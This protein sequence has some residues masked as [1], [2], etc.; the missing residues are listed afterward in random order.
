MRSRYRTHRTRAIGGMSPGP[1]AASSPAPLYTTPFTDASATARMRR[2]SAPSDGAAA[3]AFTT[4]AWSFD[5]SAP[6]RP[7]DPRTRFGAAA[8]PT[9]ATSAE[10]TSLLAAG[11]AAAAAAAV[12]AVASAASWRE[13]RRPSGAAP[14]DAA[15]VTAAEVPLAP[16][17][18]PAFRSAPS[19]AS[20]RRFGPSVSG[21]GLP[22]AAGSV[23]LEVFEAAPPRAPAAA[24]RAAAVAAERPP[25]AAAAGA[26]GAAAAGARAS[27]A[28][29]S[30]ESVDGASAAPM[31]SRFAT[32][33]PP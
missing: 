15:A 23:V 33:T 20:S 4:C 5:Q 13:I 29:G 3:F 8:P 19:R 22:A 1:G 31:V 32:V 28:A 14:G 25:V 16:P 30:C 6:P 24:A 18:P 10:V 27:G 26:G 11:D 2:T 7:D 12:T 17:A 21:V 9:G